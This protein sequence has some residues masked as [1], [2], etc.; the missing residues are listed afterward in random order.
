M[1]TM[2]PPVIA[3]VLAAIIVVRA[4]CVLHMTTPAKHHHP[5]LFYGFGYSYVLLGAGAIFAAIDILGADVGT[6]P[7]W[8]LLAG[9]C[10][11]IAF[12]RRRTECMSITHC[13]SERF[14][15]DA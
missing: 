9:S 6:V 3:C 2:I 13:P 11:L 1:W 7:Q 14:D 12:D 4:I 5:V 8:L 10:G 15:A